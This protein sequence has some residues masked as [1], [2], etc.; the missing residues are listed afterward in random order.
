[1]SITIKD[2]AKKAEV[3]YATVSRALTNHPEINEE[4]RRKVLQIAHEMGYRPNAIAKGLVTKN[5]RT[6]GLIIPD[7]T[8][9]FLSEV[10]QGMGDYASQNGYQVFLCNCNWDVQREKEHLSKL[11]S[12]RVDGIV[13][14]PVSDDISHILRHKEEIPIV[15]A[16]YKPNA[17]KCS[18]VTTEDVRNVSL[19]MEYLVKL[20]HKKI[21]YIGGPES[22]SADIARFHG[23]RS[24]LEKNAIAMEPHYVIH[25]QY[26]ISSGYRNTKQILENCDL[27]TAVLAGNDIVALGVIQAIEEFGLSVPG[28]ISVIGFDDISYA[29]LNKIQLTTIHQPKY[30]IGELSAKVLIDR[31]QNPEEKKDSYE[32]LESKLIIRKTCRGISSY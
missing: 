22:N 12:S 31:I 18:F 24:I 1:M 5:S 2:I 3:S 15:F 28:D 30:K 7:I 13:I 32:I 25:D 17:E 6:L 11:L 10:A 4:T 14:A 26:T 16:A 9:P 23:Y 29:S 21:A 8:N 27:P 20:G 19:A